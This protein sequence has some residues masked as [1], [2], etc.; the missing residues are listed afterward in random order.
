MKK[1]LYIYAFISLIAII[2]NQLYAQSERSIVELQKEAAKNNIDAQYEL[3]TEFYKGSNSTKP[4]LEKAFYWLKK[5]AENNNCSAQKALSTLYEYG[6]G[7]DKDNA[8]SRYWYLKAAGQEDYNVEFSLGVLFE[9]K[10]NIDLNKSRYWYLK[11]ANHEGINTLD[12]K[13]ALTRI[14]T[15]GI[16]TPID[17][18]QANYWLNKAK[19]NL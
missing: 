11:A 16:G 4:N 2:S 15:N 5:A 19:T 7:T 14:Y 17:L 3:G 8:K 10:T 6:E 9:N 12:A 18:V 13:T 1:N